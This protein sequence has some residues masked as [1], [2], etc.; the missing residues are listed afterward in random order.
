MGIISPQGNSSN[1]FLDRYRKKNRELQETVERLREKL[2]QRKRSNKTKETEIDQLKKKVDDLEREYQTIRKETKKTNET[3][4]YLKEKL[5]NLE[6]VKDDF[7]NQKVELAKKSEDLDRQLQQAWKKIE[8]AKLLN[9]DLIEKVTGSWAYQPK[10]RKDPDQP[11]F[12]AIMIVDSNSQRIAPNFTNKEAWDYTD[13]TYVLN[14]INNVHSE[15][16][17]DDAVFLMG[18]NDIETGR[19]G[20]A[21]A[22][23]LI[24]KVEQQRIRGQA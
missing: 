16:T 19:D 7:K 23:N 20:Q 8:E 18:T 1:S 10:H 13:N 15:N 24:R 11:R 22:E 17:Y 14:D 3:C 9:H 12:R 21:E 2:Q 5:S 6:K 4:Q